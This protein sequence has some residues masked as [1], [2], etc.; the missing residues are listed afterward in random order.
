MAYVVA[1]KG[2][3]S[4][5]LREFLQARL[6]HYMVPAGF[7]ILDTLPLMTSGKVDRRALA[8]ISESESDVSERP[9]SETEAELAKIWA[10]LLGVDRVAADSNFFDLGGHSLLAMRM[11]SRI[12]ERFNTQLPLGTLFEHR[13]LARL[14]ALLVPEAPAPIRTARTLVALRESSSA[15]PPLFLIH[16]LG[17][18]VWSYAP[19]AASLPNERR[20][21]GIQAD[22]WSPSEL[23]SLSVP[24]MASRYVDAIRTVQ[25]AGP[26]YFGGFCAGS[27][28]AYEMANQLTR[29]GE[30][31]GLLAII[32]H[33]PGDNHEVKGLFASA[34]RFFAN[35]PLWIADDLVRLDGVEIRRRLGSK[36]RLVKARLRGRAADV[37]DRLG[38]WRLP[39]HQ[40]PFIEACHRAVEQYQLPKLKGRIVL[41]R[42]RSFPSMGPWPK[43]NDFGWSGL[44]G[45]HVEVVVLPGSHG[46]L[47]GPPFVRHLATT[48]DR[49]LRGAHGD[50]T[51]GLVV[52]SGQRSV[53]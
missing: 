13:T 1:S 47:I 29:Q 39:D 2:T 31:V 22:E 51:A 49:L 30:R 24:E 26:Y 10:D 4:D 25:P 15:E 44:T 35:I 32:D 52:P 38:M 7:V 23:D 37:R 43:C 40:V 17:G 6:P 20:V 34:G 28:L 36:A 53:S 33:I 11:V 21:Y 14:A 50:A 18:E 9:L 48:L 42:A 46:T 19:L 27:V 5:E 16:A 41:L 8:N 45:D 3:T 12:H